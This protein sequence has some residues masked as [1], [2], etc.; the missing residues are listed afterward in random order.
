MRSPSARVLSNT[1]DLYRFAGTQDADAGVAADPYGAALATSVPCSVQP[2]DPTRYVDEALG[3]IV[4][5]TPYHVFF[6]AD[7]A[8]ESDDKIVWVDDAGTTHN[9][10]VSGTANEAGRGGAFS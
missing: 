9:L 4:E 2:G 3:R 8:L 7:P 1:V 6:A 10:F 5:K